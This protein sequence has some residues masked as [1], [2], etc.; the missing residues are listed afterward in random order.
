MPSAIISMPSSRHRM[1]IDPS[2]FCF[3]G[4]RS[5]PRIRDMS[6]FTTSG[7]SCA[8]L[9]SPAYPAPEIVDGDPVAERAQLRDPGA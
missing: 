7:S 5:M 2:S 3:I 1:M 4:E 9:V 6:T 8:K